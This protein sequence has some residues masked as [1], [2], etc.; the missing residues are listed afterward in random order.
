MKSTSIRVA[1]YVRVSRSDQSVNLQMDD[2]ERFATSRGWVIAQTYEDRGESG[3][4][5]RRPQ[6]DRLLDDARRRRIDIVLCFK[7]DRL[8]RSLRHMVNVLAE[9]EALGVQF[10]SATEVFDTTTPQGLLLLHL[11][12]A[13]AEFERGLL[14]ERTV[15]GMNAARRRGARIGRPRRHVDVDAV[16]E[17]RGEGVSFDNIAKKLG[18]GRA[19]IRRALERST[20]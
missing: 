15:S 17:L 6:L 20:G 13:F 1:R 16:R 9:F 2:T 18:V 8:F 3:S 5:D 10:V 19:T 11:V 4:R 14:I 12:S 7:A